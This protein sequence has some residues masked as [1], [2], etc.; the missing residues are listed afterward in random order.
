MAHPEKHGRYTIPSDTVAA[1][2]ARG[3]QENTLRLRV[4][5]GWPLERAATEP[6]GA[7]E[8]YLLGGKTAVEVAKEHG[9]NPDAFYARLGLGWTIERAATE[10][11]RQQ[12]KRTKVPKGAQPTHFV[13]ERPA[14]EVAEENGISR[15]LFWARMKVGWTALRAATEPPQGTYAVGG[16]PALEVAAEHGI[17]PAAFYSR[18]KY[19]WTAERAAT[20]PPRRRVHGDDGGDSAAPATPRGG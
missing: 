2:A 5:M 17:T 19:G 11:V 3:I 14:F 20:E 4:A 6:P 8:R 18:I 16:R 10:P 12:V 7:T 13:G 9:V 15:E 1:A